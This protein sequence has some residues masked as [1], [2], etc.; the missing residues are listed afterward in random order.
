M[1]DQTY[2]ILLS[3]SFTGD[4]TPAEH[5]S[6][7]SWIQTSP[8]NAQFAAQMKQVWDSSANHESNITIQDLDGDYQNV[9]SR[10][11]QNTNPN[12]KVVS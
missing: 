5:L 2:I 4:L 9:L 8:E 7:E 11:H 12:L 3:K 6:L 10:I 1:Q